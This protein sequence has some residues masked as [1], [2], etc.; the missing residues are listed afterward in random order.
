MKALEK[1][2]N[3]TKKE[4]NVLLNDERGSFGVKD[5]ALT[6]GAIVVIAAAAMW[7]SGDE[8]MPVIL[9]EIWD[10]LWGWIGNLFNTGGW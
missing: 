1:L 9:Q 6:V 3:L 5:I 7:L 8:G 10:G 4:A 2:T